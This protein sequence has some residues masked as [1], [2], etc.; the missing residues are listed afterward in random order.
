MKK[1][2]LIAAALATAGFAGT[3]QAQDAAGTGAFV[4]LSGGYHDLGADTDDIANAT[5][6]DVNDGGAIYG[7]VAGVDF[8]LGQGNAFAGVEGNFHLGSG[9]IDSEYGVA[10]RL[11]M[12]TD[13]GAKFYVRGG[14]Q[15]VNIDP[16]NVVDVDVPAGTFDGLDDTSGDYLVGLGAEYPIGN[17]GL[18]FNVD[19]IAFDSVRGTVG[20]VF[21]F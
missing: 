4:G 7:V 12:R 17:A 18:R 6:L 9:V 10:A 3:A 20:V 11:G 2:I 14:Y 13:G 8:P 16:Y 1:R 5:G 15:E 21:G 19:T